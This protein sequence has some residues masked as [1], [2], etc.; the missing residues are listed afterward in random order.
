MTSGMIRKD[1]AGGLNL[2]LALL[3]ANLVGFLFFEGS[4]LSCKLKLWPRCVVLNV[5][6]KIVR[7]GQSLARDVRLTSG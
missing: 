3:L 1:W 4:R 5:V 7:A 6:G 2:L